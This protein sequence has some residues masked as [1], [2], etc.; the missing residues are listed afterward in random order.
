MFDQDSLDKLNTLNAEFVFV[1]SKAQ[2][3]H[4]PTDT[5]MV[6]EGFIQYCAQ[7]FG[8]LVFLTVVNG[9]QTP[10]EVESGQYWWNAQVQGKR[11]CARFVFAP[12]E[13]LGP[14][15]FNYWDQWQHTMVAPDPSAQ[16]DDILPL[17]NHL[18]MLGEQ[19]AIATEAFMNWLACM[20][21][22]PGIKL[23]QAVFFY[24]QYGRIGKSMLYNLL[25]PVLGYPMCISCPGHELH[26]RF[27][28]ILENKRLVFMNELAREDKRDSYEKFKTRISEAETTSEKKGVA[29]AR[30]RN[31]A[32]YIV[33]S[34]NLDAL[35]FMA[36]DGRFIVFATWERPQESAYYRWFGDW[37]A[38]IGP[39]K[40]AGVLAN[41]R[42]RKDYDPYA[43]VQ[44]T[45]TSI[46]LQRESVHPV[47]DY[48][49]ELI[50]NQQAPFDVDFGSAPTLVKQLNMLHPEVMK[51]GF[52]PRVLG[53]V[54]QLLGQKGSVWMRTGR[55]VNE[56]QRFW[57]WR[58][59]GYWQYTA[60]PEE[61]IAH[62]ER[63]K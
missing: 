27:T 9:Q 60:T 56:K 18:M 34:N 23:P 50:E 53:K 36:D 51:L 43:P 54:M 17:I 16:I 28:D 61:R 44:Q 39:S 40:L 26:S 52:N 22:N 45:A 6:K 63:K 58:N 41:W 20:Y 37:C 1:T 25:A 4:I 31:T 3:Y 14:D 13:T 8:K 48:I 7:Y 12:G 55:D 57:V 32:H 21:Q 10:S 30:I 46:K 42:F 29:T 5:W 38:T 35:P 49:L 24:S 33:T 47:T 19:D 15:T 11:V 59:S 2:V 62:L